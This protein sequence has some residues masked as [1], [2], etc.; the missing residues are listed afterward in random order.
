MRHFLQ[1]RGMLEKED[2]LWM[3]ELW[4]TAPESQKLHDPVQPF[5]P[6]VCPFEPKLDGGTNVFR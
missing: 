6:K 3:R 5:D 4:E 1:S 2:N